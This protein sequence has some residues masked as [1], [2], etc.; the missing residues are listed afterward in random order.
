MVEVGAYEARTHLPSL[1]DRVEQGEQIVI[2]RHGKPIACLSP[3]TQID[4]DR[5]QAAIDAMKK[6]RR[7]RTLGGISLREF[8]EEGRRY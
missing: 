4:P 3:Y 7:G 6:L 8:R 2:T 5:V 1:L